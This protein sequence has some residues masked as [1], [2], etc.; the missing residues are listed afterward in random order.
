MNENVGPFAE[1]FGVMIS[2]KG[3]D[4]MNSVSVHNRL[5]VLMPRGCNRRVC[6]VFISARQLSVPTNIAAHGS[7]ASVRG[8]NARSR[9]SCSRSDAASHCAEPFCCFYKMRFPSGR[10][11]I[12]K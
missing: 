9:P 5:S 3:V 12:K 10:W 2:K 11:R 8:S 1:E 6:V 7:C 4:Y